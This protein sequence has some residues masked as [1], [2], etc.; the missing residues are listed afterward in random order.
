MDTSGHSRL[1]RPACAPSGAPAAEATRLV[2][3][4]VRALELGRGPPGLL[5]WLAGRLPPDLGTRPP[6]AAVARLAAELN[7][8]LR[9]AGVTETVVE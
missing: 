6:P 5:H 1:R 4:L 8:L 3:I 9:R 7:R 2:P